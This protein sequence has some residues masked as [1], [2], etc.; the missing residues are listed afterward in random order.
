VLCGFIAAAT[1]RIG[2][3]TAVIVAPLHERVIL[4]KQA[5]EVDV[6]SGG[7]LRLGVGV[8]WMEFE[9]EA[10]GRSFH[11]RGA[12]LDE[13]MALTRAL[14]SR[15]SVT[16]HGHE[17]HIDGAGFNPLPVQQPIPMW[18]GGGVRASVRRAARL[19][20]GC[21]LPG[22]YMGQLPDAD[23]L[24]APPRP[25]GLPERRHGK[26]SAR[27]I[28]WSTPA[29]REPVAMHRWIPR[30]HNSRLCL[31]EGLGTVMEA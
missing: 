18:V 20:D 9:F 4:A 25:S 13:Q 11:T 1:R 6:Q 8:G 7:R 16:Y 5:A 30:P 14:W 17:H 26:S 19:G 3:Q 10:L 15:Q 21:L 28:C 27:P 24:Q 12:R 31:R 23:A 2:L 29:S 22:R